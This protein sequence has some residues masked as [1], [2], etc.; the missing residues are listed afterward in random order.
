MARLSEAYVQR[1]AQA[2]L[3]KHYC[4][5][6]R[7]R[8]Y[9][10]EIEVVTKRRY[11]GKRADGLLVFKRWFGGLYVVSMEAKSHK[12]LPAIRPELD[13][14]RWLKNCMLF[15]ACILL[16]TFVF[17]QQFYQTTGVYKWLIPLNFGLIAAL[18]YGYATRRSYRH[19]N[20]RV[21]KQLRQYPGNEQ[22]LA[23]SDD[24]FLA[25]KKPKQEA[26]RKI[27]RYRGIGIV[28][29]G[30]KGRVH[31]LHTPLRRFRIWRDYVHFYRKENEIRAQLG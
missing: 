26:L 15:F 22:W 31:V 29:V 16:I 10:S 4:R 7:R 23:F 25:L 21:V 19:L 11:G 28:L 5:F 27:C 6:R 9:F 20:V 30:Q 17:G 18:L 3:A 8:R 13:W 24:S 12:T 2:Y 14:R 1:H